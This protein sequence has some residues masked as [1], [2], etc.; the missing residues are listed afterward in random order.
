MSPHVQNRVGSPLFV[1]N[2][3]LNAIIYCGIYVLTYFRL[4]LSQ[5]LFPCKLSY[6][7]EARAILPEG[8][9]AYQRNSN[10]LYIP[11]WQQGTSIW[12]NRGRSMWVHEYRTTNMNI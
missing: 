3:S 8:S 2:Y 1:E 11:A 7:D 4:D 9:S 6:T 5:R 10:G 12:V